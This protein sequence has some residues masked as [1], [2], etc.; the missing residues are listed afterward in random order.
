MQEAADEAVAAETATLVMPPDA[1]SSGVAS[2][3]GTI[4]TA[5]RT[6]PP[7]PQL[8][9]RA[10][11][12]SMRPAADSA[13]TMSAGSRD[14]GIAGVA[15]RRQRQ[16]LRGPVQRLAARR[17]EPERRA[18]PRDAAHRV[19]RAPQAQ[20]EPAP[21]VPRVGMHEREPRAFPF[22]EFRQGR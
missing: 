2:V 5:C 10:E 13:A 4:S 11:R 19:M 3:A 7:W 21:R 6:S 22:G 8:P 12:V 14:R 18:V 17:A 15:R 16:R 1:A 9:S 20:H